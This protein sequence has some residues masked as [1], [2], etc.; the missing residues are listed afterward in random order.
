[1]KRVAIYLPL[2]IFLVLD[3]LSVFMG[4]SWSMASFQAEGQ[5]FTFNIAAFS[6]SITWFSVIMGAAGIVGI[7]IFGSGLSD[8]STEIIMS[9]IV[10]ATLW[11]FVVSLSFPLIAQIPVLGASISIILTLIYVIGVMDKIMGD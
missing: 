5:T 7:Q 4:D 11:S 3:F 10:Y 1:M 9:I 6:D 8:E 2:T